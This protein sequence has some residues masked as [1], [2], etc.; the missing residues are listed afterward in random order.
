MRFGQENGKTGNQGGNLGNDV[1]KIEYSESLST[2]YVYSGRVGAT[3]RKFESIAN[4]CSVDAFRNA[5]DDEKW[6]DKIEN[7]LKTFKENQAKFVLL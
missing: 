3:V 6:V 2:V 1:W 5:V 4:V 7:V